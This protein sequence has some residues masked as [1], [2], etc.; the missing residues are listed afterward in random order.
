MSARLSHSQKRVIHLL[1]SDGKWRARPCR[2]ITAQALVWR[3]YAEMRNED[4]EI[5]LTRLGRRW[6]CKQLTGL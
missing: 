3:G 4:S 2:L 5:R 1:P 6:K